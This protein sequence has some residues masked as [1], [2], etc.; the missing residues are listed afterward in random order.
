[1]YTK[2]EDFMPKFDL[3]ELLQQDVEDIKGLIDY[4]KYD[5]T[6]EMMKNQARAIILNLQDH[7]E[8]LIQN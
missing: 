2:K 7:L 1:M 4:K 3:L 5:L 8:A 6:E